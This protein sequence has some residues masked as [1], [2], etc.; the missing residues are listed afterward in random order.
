MCSNVAS[1]LHWF[2][3]T[4]ETTHLFD[5]HSNNGVEK[6]NISSDIFAKKKN[7]PVDS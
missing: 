4:N 2:L 1:E 7:L 5:A 3:F 6:K